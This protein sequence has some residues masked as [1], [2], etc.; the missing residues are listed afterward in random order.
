MM[1]KI[2]A[3][4][5]RVPFTASNSQILGAI[6][7]PPGSVPQIVWLLHD[8]AR[9]WR[10]RCDREIRA[11]LPG[12]TWARCVVLVQLARYRGVN[13][14]ALARILDVAP[15][16]LTRLLDRLEADGFVARMTDPNDRRVRVLAPTARALP[17]IE[18]IYQLTRAFQDET[19][20]GI[21]R[22]EVDWLRQLLWRV[23]SNLVMRTR[24][25]ISADAARDHDHA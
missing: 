24:H 4:P 19:Q 15:I 12:M 16:T 7:A 23:R 3:R 20:L 9:L 1:I 14:A 11:Q 10:K 13:Q 25:A 22:S 5:S 6:S 2:S 17:M 18:R 21:S 8:A